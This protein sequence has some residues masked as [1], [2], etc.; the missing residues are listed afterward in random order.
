MRNLHIVMPMGGLGSRFTEAGFDTPKPL[1]P[2]DGMPMFLKSYTSLGDTSPQRS[3][4]VIIRRE[5]QTRFDLAK[6]ISTYL[7]E[8]HVVIID[9]LT[10]GA[11]ETSLCAQ[12]FMKDDEGILLLDCDLYFKSSAYNT[13]IDD[14]LSGTRGHCDGALVFFESQDSRYSYVETNNQDVIR[15]AEKQ[16]ISNHAL[17]GSYFF[18]NKSLFLTAA[19]ATLQ[20]KLTEQMAEFYTAPSF[21]YLIKM[22]LSIKAVACDEYHSFGTPEELERYEKK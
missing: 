5:H 10:R 12:D 3:L 11:L 13:L 8:C 17:I 22:G 4:T 14:C 2:V 16:V 19:N 6:K 1:I 20:T 18:G 21:N 7:P 15:T 9:T